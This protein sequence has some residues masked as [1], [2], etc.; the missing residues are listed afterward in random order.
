LAQTRGSIGDF[1]ASRER[2]YL[3]ESKTVKMRAMVENL[4]LGE[5]RIERLKEGDQTQLPRWV[6]EELVAAGLA[7]APEEAFEPVVYRCFG[8]EKMMGPLQLSPLPKDF[9]MTM[10]RTLERLGDDVAAGKGK[11]EDLERLKGNCYDLVGMRLSKLLALSS[12]PG[13]G[14]TLSDKIT[15]EEEA[16]FSLSR[17]LS[18]EWR[19]ALLGG[20]K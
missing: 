13:A 1:L 20:T 2:E 7:E 19:D 11:R 16:F 8:R 4:E 9:Y 14:G 17:S 5:Y 18:K 3:L 15:P 10:R 12:S 6:A